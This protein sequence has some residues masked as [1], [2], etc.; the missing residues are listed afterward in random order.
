MFFFNGQA[1]RKCGGEANPLAWLEN[2][3]ILPFLT[4]DNRET[5]PEMK[6]KGDNIYGQPDCKNIYFLRLSWEVK[7]KLK[8]RNAAGRMWL[9]FRDKL[10]TVI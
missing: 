3:E 8:H 10:N 9:K 4:T 2:F 7:E 6:W 5:W 1:D